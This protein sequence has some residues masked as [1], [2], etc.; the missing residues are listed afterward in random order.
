MI[1]KSTP[2]HLDNYQRTEHSHLFEH[3]SHEV[4]GQAQNCLCK[5]SLYSREMYAL[6]SKYWPLHHVIPKAQPPEHWVPYKPQ[7]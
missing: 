7:L 4:T 6:S 1:T 5:E 2:L 3:G